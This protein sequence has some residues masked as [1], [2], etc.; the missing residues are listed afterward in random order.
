MYMIENIKEDVKVQNR[1]GFCNYSIILYSSTANK[2]LKVNNL[3]DN[4][5]DE[6]FR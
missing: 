3:K 6:I 4:I 2:V 5:V 1:R